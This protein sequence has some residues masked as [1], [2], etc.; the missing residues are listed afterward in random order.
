MHSKQVVTKRGFTITGQ[1]NE[2]AVLGGGEG[3]VV[4]TG[5]RGAGRGEEEG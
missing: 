3:G 5:L 4:G 1:N 2:W